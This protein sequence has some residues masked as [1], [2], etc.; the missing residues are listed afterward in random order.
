MSK[1]AIMTK[2]KKIFDI[3]AVGTELGKI[4]ILHAFNGMTITTVTIGDVPIGCLSFSCG[5]T[6]SLNHVHT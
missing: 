1:A 5:K 2:N 4:H 3:V 6:M